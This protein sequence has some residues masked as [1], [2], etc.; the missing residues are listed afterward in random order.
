MSAAPSI[1]VSRVGAVGVIE[2]AR[3]DKFNCLSMTVH[4]AIAG[5]LDEFEAAGSGVRAVLIR[6]QGKNFCTGA[7]LEEVEGLRGDADKVDR[8]LA[9][10]HKI[11]SRFEAS[12]LPVVAACQGLA[13]AGGSELMLA[14]D[15][16]FASSD[17]R[18]GDQHAQYGLVPGW[19]G[20]QRFPRMVGLRRGLDMLFSARWI[21]AQTA[22]QWG[23]IN[24]VVE[25]DKLGE[26]S[27]EYCAK[28]ATR[29]RVGLA[30]MKRLARQGMGRSLEEGLQ[31]EVNVV[32]RELMGEDVSEGLAAFRARRPPVF[33]S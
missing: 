16:I 26:A 2:L 25:P 11:L 32:A 20:S 4:E 7:D 3:P 14:C 30:T 8:F 31:L 23:L 17:F 12:E 22:L 27:L 29:S 21:D 24:Y 9:L 10:G 13:L 28:L 33:K 5:A 18:I 1:L 19:G 6:A 15:V